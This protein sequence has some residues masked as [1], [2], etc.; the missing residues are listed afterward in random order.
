MKYNGF[1]ITTN[2]KQINS[3]DY[4]LSKSNELCSDILIQKHTQ[5]IETR[6]YL[7]SLIDTIINKNIISNFRIVN[8]ILMNDYIVTI[9]SENNKANLISRSELSYIFKE[10]RGTQIYGNKY[11]IS[12]LINNERYDLITRVAH[13]KQ[14]INIG[15]NRLSIRKSAIDINNTLYKIIQKYY[16]IYRDDLDLLINSKYN[17]ISP[18]EQHE[19]WNLRRLRELVD[20]EL[21]KLKDLATLCETTDNGTVL[22]QLLKIIRG[23][24]VLFAKPYE[25]INYNNNNIKIIPVYNISI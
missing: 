1:I 19:Y 4:S 5:D 23:L 22:D 6:V 8:D 24:K 13:A 7:E 16:S 10:N 17:T 9:K 11:K 18:S 20:S 3:L 14:K 12:Y 15:S 25:T 21:D 2:K